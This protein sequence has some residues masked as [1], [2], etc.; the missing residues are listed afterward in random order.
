MDATLIRH[1][2][3]L[4]TP[5]E[6]AAGPTETP[7]SPCSAPAVSVEGRIGTRTTE[8]HAAVHKLL[9]EGGTISDI[10]RIL[11]LDRKTVRRFARATDGHD[12]IAFEHAGEQRVASTPQDRQAAGDELHF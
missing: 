6:P 4:S 2:A 3:D 9:D 10:S 12:L 5:I 8:R 11:G 7:P 1:R